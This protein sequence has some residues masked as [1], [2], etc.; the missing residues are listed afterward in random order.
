[1]QISGSQPENFRIQESQNEA[2]WIC[3]FN[4]GPGELCV[5]AGAEPFSGPP[6]PG[7]NWDCYWVIFLQVCRM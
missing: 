5:L 2:P 1:M 4:K 6:G 3:I 7:V